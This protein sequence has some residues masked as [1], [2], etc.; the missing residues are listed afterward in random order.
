[1][2]A[3]PKNANENVTSPPRRS[4]RLMALQQLHQSQ[5]NKLN[6][7]S[8]SL[9]SNLNT[10]TSNG[11]LK[12]GVSRVSLLAK[13]SVVD[14][15]NSNEKGNDSE[16]EKEHE[17]LSKSKKRKTVNS[18]KG[19]SYRGI[20]NSINNE[21]SNEPI[22]TTRRRKSTRSTSINDTTKKATKAKK[23]K[24]TQSKKKSSSSA[25]STPGDISSDVTKNDCLP[26]TRENELKSTIDKSLQIIG[27]DEAGRGPL[28]GPVVAAA[29]IIP[30]NINGVTDSKK[31]TK[32]KD[33][34]EL[35]EQIISCPDAKY[36]IAIVD[37]KRIDEIN[38]LQATLQAMNMATTV[39]MNRELFME[40]NLFEAN[41]EQA[42]S[43]DVNGCYVVCTHNDSQ[44]KPITSIAS[45]KRNEDNKTSNKVKNNDDTIENKKEYYA[46]IDGNKIPKDF[47][48][49]CESM[50]KG[51]AKE[52]AIGAASIIA[53]VTRDRL[54]REYDI[55]YPEYDLSRHKG[56]FDQ[57]LSLE[58]NWM[59]YYHV[60][61]QRHAK[62]S[63]LIF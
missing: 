2:A 53:K 5:V 57:Y 11:N 18:V 40:N 37:A 20:D 12:G 25:A 60:N 49:D 6:A 48:C 61:A 47:P 50:V 33:R 54:M 34:E 9:L 51:D 1:M 3:N 55:L 63:N 26:R 28:A 10:G 8:F 13:R 4:A 24:A 27:V 62:K 17:D 52:F 29:A 45:I 19:K 16:I 7:N 43:S 31:L 14:E 58:L 23:A 56:E 15:K 32:E 22:E 46:I 21:S 30:L 44:G 42:A 35:Y 36:A 39:L 59:D 41:I 38:I